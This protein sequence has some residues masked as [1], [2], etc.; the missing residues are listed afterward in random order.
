MGWGEREKETSMRGR[1]GGND[2]IRENRKRKEVTMK[3]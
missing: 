1:W 2:N 3:L